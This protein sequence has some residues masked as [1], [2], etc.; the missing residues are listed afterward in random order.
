M[1]RWFHSRE[2]VPHL[3]TV[4]TGVA[5]AQRIAMTYGPSDEGKPRER[6]VDPLGVVNKSGVWYLVGRMSHARPTV[7]R[8]GRMTSALL[9][10]ERFDRGEDFDLIAYW[11]RWSAEFES[12]RPR[13][14]VTLRASPEAMRA[15][16][17][18]F[19]DGARDAIESAE[20]PDVDGWRLLTLAFEHEGA[21]V[22]RLAGFG[23]LVEVVSPVGVRDGL[24]ATAEGMLRRHQKR[25]LGGSPAPAST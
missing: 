9:L 14:P 11:D 12:S 8:V 19:G 21:A 7:F 10:D 25:S 23:D 6:V 22:Y 2:A 24:V 4:A 17:E 5:R 13:I 16:P 3:A 1:P 18:I 15:V 20:K